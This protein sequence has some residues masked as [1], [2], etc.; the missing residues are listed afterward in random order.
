VTWSAAPS[1]E[2]LQ[3]DLDTAYPNRTRPD[4]IIGDPAHSSRVSD[5]NPDSQGMVHAI[6][7]RL[8]GGLDVR[9]VLNSVIGYP[10]VW[11][12]I[13]NSIIYSRTHGWEA[14]RY[15]G[16]SPHTEHIHVSIRYTATAEQDTSPWGV[17]KLGPKVK[18]VPIDLSVIRD[19][20][21]K[22]LDLRDGKVTA[23]VHVKRL[24]RALNAKYPDRKVNVDGLV[25]K[26]TLSLWAH[27]E[28]S[29]GGQG[30]PR[31]P[32]ERSLRRLV[33]PRWKM[34]A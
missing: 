18:P 34:V 8:G 12:V 22:A 26:A 7:I 16:A 1:I 11:Y 9:E 23:R 15:T 31:V 6:D 30:R 17:V 13:H 14:L 33:A 25:G 32:D 3:R 21:L 10:R 20:F 19:E 29:V 4:W 24:Q 27:H 2:A 5:H 28:G